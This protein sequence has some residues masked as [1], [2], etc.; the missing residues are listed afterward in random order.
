MENSN[1]SRRHFHKL[2][3]FAFGGLVAGAGAAN[4]ADEK[5]PTISVDPALLLSEPHTCRGL[6][7]CKGM[8]AGKDNACAGQGACATATKHTCAGENACKGQGGCGG[9][10]GQNT[11]KGKGHCAIPLSKESWSLA[12][13]QFERLMTDAGK[14]FGK[15]PKG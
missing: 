3:A 14:K 15:A 6:N 1:L 13:K 2:T 9:Y 11:C 7:T 12:R 10:P 4:A 5:K 8:G